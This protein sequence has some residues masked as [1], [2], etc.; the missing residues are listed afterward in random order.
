M[1]RNQMPPI[2]HAPVALDRRHHQAP[3]KAQHH[4]HEGQSPRLPRGKG[5]DPGQA[6]PDQNG[7]QGPADQPFQRLG[8]RD[9]W[10]DLGAPQKLAPDILRH[11]TGLHDDD[12]KGDQHHIAPL[13][14]GDVQAQQ[15]RHMADAID[16]DHQRPLHPGHAHQEALGVPAQHGDDRDQQ[17]GIDRDQD[18][19]H[20][21]PLGIDQIVLRGQRHEEGGQ[22]RPMVAAADVL[23]RDHLAQGRERAEGK[24]QRRPGVTADQGD[25]HQHDH[26]P[27]R[28]DAVVQVFHHRV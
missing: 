10:R 19:I 3:Q 28:A 25:A 24:Q 23:Q 18:G 22:D 8:R 13:V 27:P 1:P 5:R 21:V 2:L 15:R 4:D 12:Q 20:P 11:I 14:A 26:D 16:A 6:G 7:R 17:K 9:I